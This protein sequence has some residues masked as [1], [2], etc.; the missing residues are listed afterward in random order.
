MF[1]FS[2]N[3]VIKSERK[4]KPVLHGI[5][6]LERDRDKIF[7]ESD[8]P[9]NDIVLEEKNALP[10]EQFT[11]VVSHDRITVT[12]GDDLG[13]VYG[14][15]YISEHY[16]GV[17]PF[18]FWLD[19]RFERIERIDLEETS[20]ESVT[21]AVRFRGWFFNDEV[22]MLKWKKN[23]N[24][25]DGW[26][27]AFETLL[28][29]G[30]N[31]T[32]PGTDKMSRRNR[33]MAAEMGLWITHHH[34]EPLGAE[35]FVRAYPDV[36]PNFME[37]PELFYRLWE[38]AVREQKDY[39]V[40]W[41]LCFR[42]QGDVPFWANDTS[43]QFDTPQKQGKLISDLIKKQCDI[44]KKY[45]D[46]PVFC[47]NL[48]GEI[49][50][51]Y[52]QGYIDLDEDIIK[53]RADNGFG[54]MVTRRRDNHCV[55]ISSMPDERDNGAQGIYYH[56]SFYDLQAAN[57]I[58]MLPNSVSFVDRELTEVLE[59]G[60]S[61]FWVINCS[62]VRPHAYYLD[63]VSKKWFGKSISDEEQSREFALDYYNGSDPVA[64]C[65]RKYPEAMIP[66]GMKMI[67]WVNSFILRICGL[68]HT[69]FWSTEIRMRRACTGL[70]EQG[71]FMIRR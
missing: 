40:V 58:T 45:V 19:Q 8:C 7:K 11:V 63:A 34:A 23:E 49:M 54:K 70:R 29:C 9:A 46:N 15:L 42:G 31:M 30:G 64:M 24:G 28:R 65:Y 35:M 66:Y 48:Y 69:T 2:R 39:K 21:P 41:N 3:T 16:L 44:V 10:E 60:G 68:L 33:K 47:T 5:D 6:M 61:D 67:T 13:F 1:I 17:K 36:E 59:N 62:N 53:V 37:H 18:W 51:L 32:I 56:V 12:A 14:L 26:K 52:E 25:A 27:M 43:G 57:H 4:E 71:R 38:D 55:R 20:Y 50:E 22:L